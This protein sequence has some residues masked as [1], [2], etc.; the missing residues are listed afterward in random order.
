MAEELG[1]LQGFTC[2]WCGFEGMDKVGEHVHLVNAQVSMEHVVGR[3]NMCGKFTA[4]AKWGAAV[5]FAYRALECKRRFRSSRWVA[6]YPVECATCGSPRTEPAEINVTVANPVT[7]RFRYDLYV[8]EDCQ[9][10]TAISYLGQVR[11]HRAE[12]DK[13]Y[14]S[15]WYLDPDQP[16]T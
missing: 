2:Q 14:S 16:A 1:N 8:C 12:R 7:E 5:Q 15:L 4:G 11:G 10:S 6:V 3:C 13:V 9:S